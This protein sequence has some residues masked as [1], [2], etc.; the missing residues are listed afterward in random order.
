ME[1]DPVVEQLKPL[2]FLLGTWRGSGTGAYPTIEGFAYEE[3]AT[4]THTGRPF[5]VYLQKTWDPATHRPM[6]SETGFLRMLDDG[7]VE[8]VISHAFGI[9]EVSEGVVD[10][11]TL[12]TTSRSL[13]STGTA[14]TVEIVSR[15]IEVSG[16]ELHYAIGMAFGG[17]PLQGHLEATLHRVG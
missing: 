3:E 6:H 8:A 12:E 5:L 2:E 4:F 17:H 16:D 15:R 10:A 11:T 9:A 13:S 1:A 14:K 7:R